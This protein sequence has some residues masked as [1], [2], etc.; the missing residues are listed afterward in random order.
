[1]ISKLTSQ[2][3]AGSYI[4]PPPEKIENQT[5]QLAQRITNTAST[6]EKNLS[7]QTGAYLNKKHA[8]E[9]EAKLIEGGFN[10]HILILKDS[11]N[12]LWHIVRCG[13][14]ASPSEAK[15]AAAAIREKLGIEA[16]VRPANTW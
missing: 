14:Y 10:P 7:V 4:Q 3:T 13:K 16:I 5:P 8:G 2:K 6:N 11:K 1:M 15:K 12:K 9:M